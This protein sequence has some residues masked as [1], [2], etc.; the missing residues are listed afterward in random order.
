MNKTI[1][2]T[3]MALFVCLGLSSAEMCT[4]T[5][6]PC[7][8]GCSMT[9]L[10]YMF[11]NYNF[12]TDPSGVGDI[13]GWDTSCITIMHGMFW[14]SNFNQAIGVWDTDN[15]VDMSH[16]FEATSFNQDIRY[17]H[18]QNVVSM[19]QMF[20]DDSD[21]NQPLDLWNVGN[22]TDMSWMFYVMA[23]DGNFNQGLGSWDTS[24]V[25][26]MR[27]MFEGQ[28]H[29]NQYLG[30]WDVSNVVNFEW[31]FWNDYALD[32]NFSNW[33]TSSAT[34]MNWMFH[35]DKLS[36]PNYDSLLNAWAV[37]AQHVITID[38]GNSLHSAAGT[39]GYNTLSNFWG[40]T[41]FD[42]GFDY[43]PV[44]DAATATYDNDYEYAYLTC[45]VHDAEENIT[46]NHEIWKDG[47][48][49]GT[50][51]TSFSPSRQNATVTLT[52]L[53]AADHTWMVRCQG[54]DGVQLSEW[55]N[56]SI[57]NTTTPTTCG[58]SII[59]FGE[60]CDRTNL[61][62]Q[63]C[64]SLGYKSGT[65][66]CKAS[67]RFNIAQCK[68]TTGGGGGGGGN[69]P[70]SESPVTPTTPGAAAPAL[71]V[72]PV[73][74]PIV[75]VVTNVIAT[76]NFG[77]FWAN[78]KLIFANLFSEPLVALREIGIVAT[79]FPV[80]LVIVVIVI[81]GLITLAVTRSNPKKGR[82]RKKR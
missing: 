44:V 63:S 8:G 66:S 49:I 82:R 40:W 61:N 54:N 47:I 15:V 48:M 16:M 71:S 78:S 67:C 4:Q 73:I 57:L 14:N 68:N 24:K 26:L 77:G 20:A 18:T 50:G 34:E 53:D 62:G 81:A 41:I 1:Y 23:G 74:G 11:A 59:D 33:V 31:M 37:N 5:L 79:K 75:N 70:P 2:L 38:F 60:A 25:T 30:H 12:I 56:S 64:V 32:Q 58:N 28:P 69:F 43:P 80:E 39:P 27:G 6:A 7:G 52:Q 21:F 13:T 65:L 35:N 42:G 29:F 9:N 45:T 10:T 72:I 19:A 51:G 36:T 46:I 55:T 17:W 76:I 22:V 3:M